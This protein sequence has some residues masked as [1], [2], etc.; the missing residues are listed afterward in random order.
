MFTTL[1][2]IAA[3][4]LIGFFIRLA[5]TLSKQRWAGTYHFTLTCLLLPPITFVITKVIAGNIALSLGMIGALSIVR[6]RNPVKSSLELTIYFL[7][8]TIGI[9]C[10]VNILWA[11]V[12]GGVSI[13]LIISLHILRE[14][15]SIKNLFFFNPSFE[16][17]DNNYIV[18]FKFKGNAEKFLKDHSVITSSYDKQANETSLKLNF[19]K[20]ESAISFVKD[21]KNEDSL[22]FYEL[23]F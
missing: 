23:R 5:L 2:S 18:E 21:I 3:S 8:I 22:I 10:S 14:K 9:S 19:K 17:G 20:K 12:L 4:S 6:F 11:I 1:I 16:E 13:F 7:L 15:I